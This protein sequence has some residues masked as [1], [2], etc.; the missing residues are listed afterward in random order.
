MIP[1]ET[2]GVRTLHA[3]CEGQAGPQ[4]FAR[5]RA[6]FSTYTPFLTFVTHYIKSSPQPALGI[7]DIHLPVK[8]FPKRSSRGAHGTL[9]LRNVLHVPTEKRHMQWRLR[10]RSRKPD[11]P[12]WVHVTHVKEFHPANHGLICQ[13]CGSCLCPQPPKGMQHSLVDPLGQRPW[14][15]VCLPRVVGSR[16]Q[17][18]W[19]K[20]GP[21]DQETNHG[22][23]PVH[24]C[25]WV[26]GWLAQAPRPVR[27]ATDNTP[28]N[29]EHRTRH[30]TRL[31]HFFA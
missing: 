18:R 10:L 4:S 26:A 31:F 2:A 12:W 28:E 21:D 16:L 1:H 13:T 8:M 3:G 27:T 7:G 20:W 14:L 9:H 29:T 17:M 25:G 6:W 22:P 5:D 15:G 23:L 24:S 30:R 19:A 11:V